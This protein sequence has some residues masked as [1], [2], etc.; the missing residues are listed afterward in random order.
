MA[1]EPPAADGI[2]LLIRIIDCVYG[3]PAVGVSA[4][5]MTN[6]QGK[7]KEYARCR[8]D[9]TGRM[10]LELE[11]KPASRLFQIDFDINGYFAALGVTPFYPKISLNFRMPVHISHYKLIVLITPSSYSVL[12]EE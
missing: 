9:A 8:T 12:K 4:R 10:T 3:R 1:A 6:P 7:I 2:F 5:V 11:E